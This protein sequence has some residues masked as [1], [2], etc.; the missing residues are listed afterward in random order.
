M[1]QQQHEKA[2][3]RGRERHGDARFV[4]KMA[5]HHVELPAAEGEQIIFPRAR[6]FRP[7][8]RAAHRG[9]PQQSAHARD[10]LARLKRLAEIIVAADFEADHLVRRVLQSREKYDRQRSPARPRR[11]QPAAEREA[12]LARHHDV[13]QDERK[14]AA[15]ERREHFRA[16]LRALRSV[17]VICERLRDKLAQLRVVVDY[18]NFR[19]FFAH[20]RASRSLLHSNITAR[21]TPAT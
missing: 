8:L 14:S 2:E 7:R 11:A 19:F 5:R 10:K 9:A 15:F 1:L 18:E 4:Y 12:V 17:A 21:H 20:L 13:E 3:L 6:R 16:V